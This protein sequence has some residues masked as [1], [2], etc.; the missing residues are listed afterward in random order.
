M[1][2]AMRLIGNLE[3]VSLITR[4]RLIS[5]NLLSRFLEI[6]RLVIGF[7]KGNWPPVRTSNMPIYSWNPS[8]SMK[9]K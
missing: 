3:I 5:K 9:I 4:V 7:M 1:R 2:F 6:C 8:N